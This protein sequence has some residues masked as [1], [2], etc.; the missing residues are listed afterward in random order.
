[1]HSSSDSPCAEVLRRPC[2]WVGRSLDLE[3]LEAGRLGVPGPGLQMGLTWKSGL[4]CWALGCEIGG[5][6]RRRLAR[7]AVVGANWVALRQHGL[8]STMS[9]AARWPSAQGEHCETFSNGSA[10]RAAHRTTE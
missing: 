1:V 2:P 8:Q 7:T 9:W 4:G 6:N 10:R 5:V 3:P